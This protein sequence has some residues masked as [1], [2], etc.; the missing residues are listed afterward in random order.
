MDDV[1]LD[2]VKVA[3]LQWSWLK[4]FGQE[5]VW[6]GSRGGMKLSQKYQDVKTLLRLM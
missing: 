1:A 6:Y 4:I 3:M 5:A 2:Q